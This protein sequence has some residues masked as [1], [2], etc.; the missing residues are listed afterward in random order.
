M[1]A[2]GWW[3]L[4]IW[5]HEH[6]RDSAVVQRETR[7]CAWEATDAEERGAVAGEAGESFGMRGAGSHAKGL[8]GEKAFG[9]IRNIGFRL[10]TFSSFPPFA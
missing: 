7:M 6:Q 3:V 10:P 8:K 4:R 2:K 5:E 9:Q 1:R